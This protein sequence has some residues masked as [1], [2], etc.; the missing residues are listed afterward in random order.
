M[1][2]IT[3]ASEYAN[4]D[5]FDPR[6]DA[7]LHRRV[8]EDQQTEARPTARGA[9]IGLYMCRQI[10]DLHGGLISCSS[11]VDDRGTCIT[12]TLPTTVRDATLVDDAATYVSH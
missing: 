3:P 11:G 5:E 7:K 8:L 2:V 6:R 10:V 4:P 1:T 9:G 12:V